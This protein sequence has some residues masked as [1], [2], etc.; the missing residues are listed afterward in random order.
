MSKQDVIDETAISPEE[1]AEFVA[2]A[3]SFGDEVPGRLALE[4]DVGNAEAISESWRGVCEIGFDRCILPEQFGGTGLP[5]AALPA[6][7]EEIAAG[8]AGVAML[9]L[10]SNI[11]LSLLPEEQLA[12]VGDEQRYVFIPAGGVHDTS[13]STP[14][15]SESGL[16]GTVGLAIGAFDADVFVF[17]CHDDSGA[18]VTAVEARGSGVS[19]RKITDQMA[20]N[21][22]PAAEIELSDAPAARVGDDVELKRASA[23]LHLGIAA[24]ARGVARRAGRLALEYAENRYQGGDQIIVHGAVRDMLARIRERELA[25]PGLPGV[26]ATGQ[27]AEVELDTALA[28]KIAHSDAAVASTID[29]VQVFGGMGYMRET[30]VEKLMRDAKY[31]QLFPRPNWVTRDELLELQRSG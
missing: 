24:I 16:S 1:L 22:A 31:C 2:V 13:K 5:A 8:D 18:A 14:A 11:A 21:G 26:S 9:T 17:A 29:A 10:L 4:L 6:V 27:I 3:R 25:M 23:I 15:L 28:M 12:T 7:I 20:I 30:G 19:V